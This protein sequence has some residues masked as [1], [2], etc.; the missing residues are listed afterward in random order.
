[1]TAAETYLHKGREAHAAGLHHDAVAHFV[2][3]LKADPQL[4]SAAVALGQ[5]YVEVGRPDD[6]LGPLEHALRNEPKNSDALCLCGQ[7]LA[8]VGQTDLAL[9]FL[10]QAIS[11]A[12]ED[13]R[14]R[15]AM[16]GVLQGIEF[17]APHPWFEQFLTQCFDDPQQPHAD[18]AIA[19]LSLLWA[20]PAIQ[21]FLAKDSPDASDI[22]K[23]L[24]EPLLL[25]LLSKT[26]IRSRAFEEF[27]TKLRRWLAQTPD[28]K[29]LALS[30]C[31]AQQAFI[32]GYVQYQSEAESV[33]EQSLSR[34]DITRLT[35][36]ELTILASY[37]A[38]AQSP[39]AESMRQHSGL[40]EPVERVLQLTLREP[41]IELE[42][43]TQIPSSTSVSDAVSQRVQAQ[44]E[45]HPYPRW[46]NVA[47]GTSG[48]RRLNEEIARHCRVFEDSRWP[49]HP[50]V[51]VPGCGTGYHPLSLARMHHE[52]Q[53]LAI[54]LSLTSLAYARRKQI[55]LNIDNVR[56][57]Q[58]DLLELQP[59]EER[60]DYIDCAGVLHHMD[61][62]LEGWRALTRLLADAGVM[63]IGL[64][65]ELAR[66]KIVI[67][68]EK[69]AER[70]ISGIPGAIREFRQAMM[71]DPALADLRSIAQTAG[72]FFSMGEIRDL[73]FHV[74]EHR[75]TIPMLKEHLE[76][77]G[78]QFG[79]FLIPDRNIASGFRQQYPDQAQWLDLDCWADFE[80]RYPDTFFR[81]YQFYCLRRP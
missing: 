34:R 21:D 77:L 76:T 27:F 9:Q 78:L 54:D 57:E 72:D 45:E 55:E 43:K 26:I 12:P 38:L 49:H 4:T 29:F 69:I 18:I 80:S 62:P 8:E 22:E 51:L 23:L 30:A 67:A 42:L 36:I 14:Y 15:Q 56:F 75:F 39:N 25:R 19:A 13:T 73:L 44:Y 7:A 1:M 41:L 16:V 37:R 24:A 48:S 10:S 47:P 5:L 59:H 70:G 31:V 46:I 35:P 11:L 58:A 32:T 68:R 60:F 20:K 81:M 2:T 74:Q 17:N 65:S 28:E 61:S 3:A 33:A 52:S 40:P 66:R 50:Q 63:R 53:I 71:T 6:A 79:G 64:Y